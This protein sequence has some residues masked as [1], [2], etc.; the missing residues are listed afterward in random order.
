MEPSGRMVLTAL[1]L[2][3]AKGVTRLPQA[4]MRKDLQVLLEVLG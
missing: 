1:L 4:E 3:N 2:D